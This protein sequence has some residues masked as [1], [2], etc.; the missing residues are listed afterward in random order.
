MYLYLELGQLSQ[1][2]SDTAAKD[3]MDVSCGIYSQKY[4]L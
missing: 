3:M 2:K 1:R 4:S